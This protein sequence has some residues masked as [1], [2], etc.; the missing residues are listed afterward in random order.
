MNHQQGI[1]LA[2]VLACG[3]P[4]AG[5]AAQSPK[6]ASAWTYQRPA[7]CIGRLQAY[8]SL[9]SKKPLAKE[10]R[11][12]YLFPY[13]GTIKIQKDGKY[14]LTYHEEITA[15]YRQQLS[16]DIYP[17]ID[18][19]DG[20]EL[21][22]WSAD[23]QRALADAVAKRVLADNGAAG[24]HI[25]VEPFAAAHVPFYAR[26]KAKLNEGGKR[27]TMFTLD[28]QGDIYANADMVVLSG[29]DITPLG[30]GPAE[31]KELLE[32]MVAAALAS[33]EKSGCKLMVGIPLASSTREFAH[34]DRCADPKDNRDTG[35]AQEEW[36]SAALE[37][38][39]KHHD[40]PVY[41]GPSIW[42]FRGEG[43]PDMFHQHCWFHP[44]DVS[45]SLLEKL[46]SLGSP[47]PDQ[48]GKPASE[49]K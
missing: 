9:V 4:S 44:D 17:N 22:S 10:L 18:S 19:S 31:Y 1:F 38:L 8:D 23:Q 26:L 33:C 28:T 48:L 46:A 11:L 5:Q 6:G 34:R 20:A 14:S 35:H 43:G 16:A 39:W 24:V 30:K 25:D 2:L 47:K 41:V 49:S 37:V 45:D 36:L 21:T 15:S 3:I 29:Y 40:D 42:G 27:T 12:K 32:T 7:D 13:A